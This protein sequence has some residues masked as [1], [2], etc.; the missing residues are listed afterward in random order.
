MRAFAETCEAVSATR[1]RTE[2][3][4]LLAAYFASRPVD[5]AAIA[6]VFSTGRA[7]PAH[8]ETTLQVGGAMLSRAIRA[9][10][11]A[12]EAELA[13][14]YRR[15]GDLGAAAFDV[16]AA[17]ARDASDP[18]VR[19]VERELRR[20]AAA[21]GAAAKQAALEAL[22]ARASPLVVKY[23]LKIVTGDLRIGSKEA[24]VEEA[25][26][27]A[28][29]GT[30]ADVQRA[31]M[32]LG[33]VGEALRLAA[34]R[35][36]GEARMRLFHPL[37]FMLAAAAESADEAFASFGDAVVEDKYDGIRAQAHVSAR[38]GRVR[39]FS[40]TRD[41]VTSSFPELAAPL[42]TL[43]GELVLDGEV[44]AYR[45]RALPFSEL[46]RRLG[47]KAPTEAQQRAVPVAYVAFDVLYQDGALVV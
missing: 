45:D 21:R 11:G 27:K 15:H 38:E 19:D 25:I 42:A 16:F 40:R 37:G 5:E 4:A 33:D 31:N 22:L 44:L 26:A 36:L 13:A 47:R 30:L 17:R 20:I 46:Q 43:P 3:I 14:A 23:L 24:L 32:L 34:A 2:K 29:G 6:V 28:F 9:A 41:D 35:A 12:D 1:K 8:E 7:F 18:S 39:L 10:S